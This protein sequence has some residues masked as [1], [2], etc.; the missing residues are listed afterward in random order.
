MKEIATIKF[1][2]ADT[3]DDAL[4]VVRASQGVVALALSLRSNGDTEVFLS[5]PD[6]DRLVQALQRAARELSAES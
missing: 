5:R 3:K 6:C 4:A 1:V 2:D